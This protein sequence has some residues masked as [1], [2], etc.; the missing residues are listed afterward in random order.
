MGCLREQL[1]QERSHNLA[2][3]KQIKVHFQHRFGA[4]SEKMSTHQLG[5]VN[6]AESLVEEADIQQ[7]PGVAVKAHHRKKKPRFSIPENY[8]REEIIHK[9]PEEEKICLHYGHKLQVIGS[10]DHEQIDIMPAQIN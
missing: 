9:L 2:L 5:L 10:N 6:E 4:S 8:P 7:E 1:A 3:Q